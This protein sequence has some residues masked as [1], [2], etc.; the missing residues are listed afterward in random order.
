MRH[1]Q[2]CSI[3]AGKGITIA[4]EKDVEQQEQHE[5]SQIEDPDR[6]PNPWAVVV[7]SRHTPSPTHERPLTNPG[8]RYE[9]C[10]VWSIEQALSAL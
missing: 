5:P 3:A 6:P 7:I 9:A 4:A 8:L 2:E 10:E 1:A